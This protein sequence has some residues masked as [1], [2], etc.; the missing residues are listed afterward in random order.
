MLKNELKLSFNCS[1][2]DMLIDIPRILI[3]CIAIFVWMPRCLQNVN[4]SEAVYSFYSNSHAIPDIIVLANYSHTHSAFMYLEDC[5]SNS[6]KHCHN[7]LNNCVVSN[8]SASSRQFNNTS[9][10]MQSGEHL[11][12]A[13]RAS[14]KLFRPMMGKHTSNRIFQFWNICQHNAQHTYWLFRCLAY[15]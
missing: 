11:Q 10:W 1:S 12:M 15:V 14:R 7:V 8:C 9:K 2:W 5:K 3:V 6:H 13:S 4:Q